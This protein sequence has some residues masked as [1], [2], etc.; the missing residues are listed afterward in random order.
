MDGF[1]DF[2]GALDLPTDVAGD[3]GGA[4]TLPEVSAYN[5]QPPFTSPS[6]SSGLWDFASQ[7]GAGLGK[8]FTGSPLK[9]FSGALGL[10]ATGFGIAN[11]LRT[12]GAL[13][14]QTETIEKGQKAAQAAAAPAVEFG[15]RQ[16]SAA[17]AGKLPG[18]MQAAVEQWKQRAKA[19]ARAR[20]AAM[21]LGNSSDLASM[22]AQIDLM[23]ESM[24]AQLLQG[25]EQLGLEG[26]RTGVS[27]ATGGAESAQQQQVLLANL[28]QGAN[29]Q[30]AKLGATA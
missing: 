16:L 29:A 30:L 7:L 12:A 20:L 4:L 5:F 15:Q 27:A 11:Q 25:Q 10:G 17:E 14:R 21:G 2:A 23:G 1:E 28:L 19:D 24:I 9:A 22:E 26:L 6:S 13:N 8:E 3:V 18:P